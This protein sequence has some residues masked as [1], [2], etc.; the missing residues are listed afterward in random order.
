MQSTTVVTRI[1]EC[2]ITSGIQAGW[3]SLEVAGIL[4]TTQI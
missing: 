2:P 4:Q 1:L 3:Y